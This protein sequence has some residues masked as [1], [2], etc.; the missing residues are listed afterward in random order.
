MARVSENWEL[1]GA[2]APQL[3]VLSNWQPIPA[4]AA[5]A[6]VASQLLVLGNPE[7]AQEAPGQEAPRPAGAQEATGEAQQA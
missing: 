3:L 7:G 4:Q 5:R 6:G 2:T 1:R